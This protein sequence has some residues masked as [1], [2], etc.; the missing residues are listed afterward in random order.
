GTGISPDGRIAAV[1]SW[2]GDVVMCDVN[3]G[4]ELA[5]FTGGSPVR[6]IALPG[7]EAEV[8][9]GRGNG[10]IDQCRPVQGCRRIVEQK[11]AIRR[12][13]AESLP[14]LIASTG[15]DAVLRLWNRDTRR[16]V[17]TWTQLDFNTDVALTHAGDLVAA[18]S[19]RGAQLW[20]T[21][22]G[23]EVWRAERLGPVAALALSPTGDRIAI[24]FGNEVRVQ[25][26]NPDDLIAESCR[27]LTRN[28]TE[29]EWHKFLPG[30]RYSR[31]CRG[32]P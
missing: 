3:S 30:V 14:P 12:L 8:I 24:A 11:A 22:T 19:D 25:A 29:N 13:A 4:R 26:T 16:L 32:L 1:G 28:L 2:D 6:A 9:V 7:N 18:S 5:R 20:R 15:P 23:E 10:D 31:T 17:A 21:Q 27:Q